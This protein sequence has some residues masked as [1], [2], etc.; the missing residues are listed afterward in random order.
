VARATAISP[1]ARHPTM[2]QFAEELRNLVPGRRRG[3]PPLLV[4]VVVLLALASIGL[5]IYL[6]P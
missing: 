6:L 3:V 1:S 2:A 4:A 5:L